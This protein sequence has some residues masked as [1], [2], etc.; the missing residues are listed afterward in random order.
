ME[1]LK[2]L[3]IFTTITEKQAEAAA[4]RS[5]ERYENGNTSGALDGV[6]IAIKDNFCV[7][8]YPTTC[9]SK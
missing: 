1:K 2:D 3:N 7:K 8:D 6:Q 5:S 9:A 4:V